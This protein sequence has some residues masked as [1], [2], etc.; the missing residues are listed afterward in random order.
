ML[1][2]LHL[3]LGSRSIRSA[4]FTG[5]AYFTDL[6]DCEQRDRKDWVAQ[7]GVEGSQE[8]SL[9]AWRRTDGGR[10]ADGDSVSGEGWVEGGRQMR[11]MICI[12]VGERN[13]QNSLV[14]KVLVWQAQGLKLSPQKSSKRL[15]KNN[16]GVVINSCNLRPTLVISDQGGVSRPDASRGQ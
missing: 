6:R 4:S 16:P 7:Q 15:N 9:S 12:Q 10:E 5:H 14:G 8:A 1:S 13:L 11:L 3:P 2:V